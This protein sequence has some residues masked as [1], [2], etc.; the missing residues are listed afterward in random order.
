MLHSRCFRGTIQPMA[1]ITRFEDLLAWQKARALA[2]HIRE[3][4]DRPPF[5]RDFSLRDQIRA[6][7]NSVPLNIAEGFERYRLAEFHH[8]L[9]IAKASCGEVR[10]ALYLAFDAHYL[11]EEN[12]ARLLKETISVG[13]IIG[14]LRSAIECRMRSQDAARSTQHSSKRTTRPCSSKT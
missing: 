8:F 4:S 13:E 5:V 10:S 6:A 11:T 7:A 1:K 12:L 2:A 3:A 14:R 9:S